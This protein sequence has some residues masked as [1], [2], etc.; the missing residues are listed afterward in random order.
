MQNRLSKAAI[1][2]VL[3]SPLFGAEATQ[4]PLQYA[5][6]AVMMAATTVVLCV[7]WSWRVRRLKHQLN[8]SAVQI[9]TLQAEVRH[10]SDVTGRLLAS[11]SHE[12]RTPMNGILGMTELTL[13]EELTPEHRANL[14][15]VRSSSHALLSVINE[16]VDLSNVESG[17]LQLDTVGFSI[18][19]QV[20][21]VADVMRERANERGLKLEWSVSDALPKT[22]RG[23]PY[24]LRQLLLNIIGNAVKF[25]QAGF[26]RITVDGKVRGEGIEV[27]VSVMDT[28]IGM[29]P[30]QKALVLPPEGKD[31]SE[32]TGF[33]LVFARKLVPLM[34]GKLWA[35]STPGKGS[36]FHFTVQVA[37]GQQSG[38]PDADAS[39]RGSALRRP[40][41]VLVAEDNL[42]NQK[43]IASILQKRGHYMTVATDGVSAV[44]MYERGDFDVVL[45]DVH[46]PGMD[47][48]LATKAIR[49][50]EARRAGP[51]IRIIAVTADALD[52]DKERCINAGMDG[53]MA[54]PIDL[55]RLLVALEEPGSKRDST[56]T[57]A[58]NES[59]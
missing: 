31:S 23:D 3:A 34:G 1:G 17:K 2:V 25:T 15:L 32:S 7:I 8:D 14:L 22:V 33:G 24:R 30:E 47:G 45:M 58:R 5:P 11:V 48:L 21:E 42:L 28:G 27:H 56:I 4:A 57:S 29:S 50:R 54:K 59:A 39:D 10:H 41:R 55:E 12:I 38:E 13:S 49:E 51:R 46:M 6:G 26:V 52:G 36:T 37:T 9:E 43:V 44:S 35:D 40:L 16:I 20:K 19:E 53:Y 18:R